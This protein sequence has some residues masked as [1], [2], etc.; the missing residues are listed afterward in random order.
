MCAHHT[1]RNPGL[2][3]SVL[4]NKCPR[5]RQG[6]LFTVSNPYRLSTTM[7]MPEHCPVCG[8]AYELEAGFYFGTGYVSYGLSVF[9]TGLCFVAW[10]L[11]I[12]ISI[13]DNSIF[14][15]LGA[16]GVLLILLQPVLQRLARSIWITCFVRYNRGWREETT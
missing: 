2:I 4:T 8:Q 9:I 15:W 3:L 1:D 12:G 11:L 16:N 6:D 13:Y 5:C 7:R 14:W 10:Y